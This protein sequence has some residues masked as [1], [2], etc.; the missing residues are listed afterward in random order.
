MNKEITDIKIKSL[1]CAFILSFG[2]MHRYFTLLLF[3]FCTFF[4]QAQQKEIV[5][6]TH[7]QGEI[8]PDFT[9]KTIDGTLTVTFNIL[10][11]TDSVYLD[12]KNITAF[13]ISLKNAENESKKAKIQSKFDQNH[14]ILFG[15]FSAGKKYSASISY[16]SKPSQAL[17][18]VNNEGKSQLWTQGQGKYTSNWLPSI[19]DM[20]DKIE[21]DLQITAPVGKTVI[22]NGKLTKK[23]EKSGEVVWYFDMQNPISSYLV[24]LAIGD[25]KN[26]ELTS[27]S[28]TPIALYY[29]PEDLNEV[30]PT[31]RYTKQIFD[32]LE[33]EIGV[34]YPWQ[35]YKEVPVKD[36]LYAGM[37]NTTATLF[38]DSFVVDSTGFEDRN[39]VNVN[40]HEL[41]HQWFGDLVTETSGTH[42]WLQEGFA[43]YYAL[44]A[45]KEVFGN[46]YFY[47]KLYQT[48][49]QLKELSDRGKGEKLLNPGASSLTFYQKGAWALHILRENIGDEAFKLVVI[50]YLKKHQFENVVTADFI[51]AAEKASGQD[52]ASFEKDWLEQS[53]F[54]ADVALESLKKSEFIRTYLELSA[55]RK[56]ALSEKREVIEKMLKLPNDYLGQEAVYQLA[57]APLDESLPLYKKAIASGN[58]WVRQAVALS[59]QEVPSVMKTDYEILLDDDSYVTREAALLALWVSFPQ[60]RATYLGK[61]E[62]VEGFSDKNIET[63]WLAL[64]IATSSYKPDAKEERYNQLLDYTDARHPFQVRENAF[65]YLYQLQLYENRSLKNL[66]LGCVHFNWRFAQSCRA[67]LDLLLEET[68]WSNA[69]RDLKLNDKK[70]ED[71]L[72]KKLN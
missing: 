24:A 49:E 3:F 38:S 51:A 21:F 69:L 64:S 59:M 10:K 14:L 9:T 48:A 12:A 22:S 6:F 26:K 25:Y 42:H 37:E 31:Y 55:L 61:L 54:Q 4:A 1:I 35:N 63:L 47:F 71:Y 29:Y 13:E 68:M 44:L 20:N 34:S 43:T 15:S 30:E 53:A 32:F 8:T 57:E 60:D 11:D 39:Y 40:A 62:G 16:T 7:I 27:T 52:L 33:N 45:E 23:E 17:Y 58:R 50:S 19:D 28:G 65:K 67:I 70:A 18:F 2:F 41:A 5:D 56:I 66:V 36:F 46:D 72:N